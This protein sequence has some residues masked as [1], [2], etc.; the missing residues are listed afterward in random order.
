LNT[1]FIVQN[2]DY[3]DLGYVKK[4]FNQPPQKTFFYTVTQDLD[5]QMFFNPAVD[6]I[7]TVQQNDTPNQEYGQGIEKVDINLRLANPFVYE[8][9]PNIAYFDYSAFSLNQVVYQTGGL[10]YGLLGLTYGLSEHLASVLL[11]DLTLEQK[12]EFFLSCNNTKALIYDDKFFDRTSFNITA[13]QEVI[14]RTLSNNTVTDISTTTIYKNTTANNRIYL[15]EITGVMAKGE[16]VEIQNLDNNSSFRITWEDVG[17]SPATM[18]YNSAW[19]KMYLA[20]GTEI[21][22][23]SYRISQSLDHF[24]Y[25]SPLATQ[26]KTLLKNT[27]LIRLQKNSVNNLT[28]KIE[29]LNTYHI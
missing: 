27:E 8:C 23:L 2:K 28:I 22:P 19:E 17:A 13:D 15:I 3:F 5:V 7:Q 11:S 16:W 26:N 9:K 1:S 18:Y 4:V 21:N 14:N 24:L 29:N 20:N 6:T 25:F 10:T 12:Q